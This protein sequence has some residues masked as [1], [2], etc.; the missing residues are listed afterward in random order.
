MQP[1]SAN[2]AEADELARLRVAL[3]AFRIW[4]EDACGRVRYI[5]RS[6]HAGLNPHTVVTDDLDELREALAN[7]RPG[8]ARLTPL[9]G[10]QA[11]TGRSTSGPGV[12]TT[13]ANRTGHRHRGPGSWPAS[14]R[15]P[16]ATAGGG[17]EHI[18]AS[19][20]PGPPS[21]EARG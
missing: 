17:H 7:A 8:R 3:P 5:A 18:A 21:G 2:D 16:P 13:P 20:W 4:R 9:P 14:Q 15:S 12:P 10:G 19:R 1:A 11:A 6:Q